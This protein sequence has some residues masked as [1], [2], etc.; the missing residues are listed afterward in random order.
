M[1]I[2]GSTTTPNWYNSHSYGW[3]ARI[4]FLGGMITGSVALSDSDINYVFLIAAIS[5]APMLYL[6][7][8]RLHKTQSLPPQIKPS[9]ITLV[10]FELSRRYR[11]IFW[12]FVCE[13][14]WGILIFSAVKI[15]PEPTA[16]NSAAILCTAFGLSGYMMA[17]FFLAGEAG[18]ERN[19][20]I[21]EEKMS[22]NGSLADKNYIH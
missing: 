8:K 21:I 6:A 2:I 3:Y 9:C 18:Q 22:E 4:T 10:I 1:D 11:G 15:I 5:F 7:M 17:K 13:F 14:S 12:D 16:V 20:W 19:K